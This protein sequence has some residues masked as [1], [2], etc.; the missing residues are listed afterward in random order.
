VLDAVLVEHARRAGAVVEFGAA[1]TGVLRD[2]AGAVNGVQLRNARGLGVRVE[3]APLVIAADGRGSLIAREV[4]AAVTMAARHPGSGLYGYWANLPTD[5][6]E[7]FY[8]PGLSAGAIPTNG[9]H[10]A[11]FIGGRPGVINAAV[12]S[13]GSVEAFRRFATAAGLG[14]RLADADPVGALR[15]V[16]SLPPGYLR[17][18][19]GPG[20]ALVGDAGHWL[21]PISTHGMTAALRDAALLA[22]AVIATNPGRPERRAALAHYQ[23]V[24]DRLS[25]PMVVATDEIAGYDWDLDRIRVLLRNLASAMTDE[26]ELLAGLATGPSER[27]RR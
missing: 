1:V 9:G 16:R 19:H 8:Q 15:F 3:S 26:V 7:W 6:Y 12:D 4:G 17:A 18:A 11:V 10:T 24:R 21:D 27:L 14:D 23:D 13:C 20:W 25:A 5:G 22:Q 2:A